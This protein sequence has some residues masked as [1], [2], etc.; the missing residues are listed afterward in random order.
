MEPQM[1]PHMEQQRANRQDPDMG[2]LLSIARTAAGTWS[3]L[4]PLGGEEWTQEDIDR[5]VSIA[6]EISQSE[7]FLAKFPDGLNGNGSRTYLLTSVRNRLLRDRKRNSRLE[8]LGDIAPDGLPATRNGAPRLLASDAHA[9]AERVR[10]MLDDEALADLRRRL[11]GERGGRK[12]R[13]TPRHP[14]GPSTRTQDRHWREEK[15]ALLKVWVGE[16]LGWEEMEDVL[17]SLHAILEI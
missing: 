13:G 2:A 8:I 12:G 5:G 7:A 16:G 4:A 9:L 14:G 11:E 17:A 6:Y 10:S 1:T 15:A 3:W